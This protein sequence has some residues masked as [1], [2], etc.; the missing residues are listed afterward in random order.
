MRFLGVWPL[1][2][3]E[4]YKTLSLINSEWKVTLIIVEQDA[5]LT[6]SIARYCYFLETG[7]N[8]ET[9]LNIA[10]GLSEEM[11][12][13]KIIRKVYNLCQ[14]ISGMIWLWPDIERGHIQDT[15]C[16]T[17]WCGFPN[18]ERGYCEAK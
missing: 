16:S 5:K 9:G 13:S 2:V 1:V 3:R 14:K 7:F 15:D 10:N 12:K 11:A 8:I 6:L 4:I 18:T 17:I